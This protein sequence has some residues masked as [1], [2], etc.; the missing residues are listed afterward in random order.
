MKSFILTV[1]LPLVFV[2]LV[3]CKKYEEGPVISL[4]SKKERVAN[5]WKYQA[6]Y[7]N[8]SAEVLS[9]KEINTTLTLT[10]DG[11]LRREERN[12]SINIVGNGSWDFVRDKEQISMTVSYSA[13]GLTYSE[14]N[15][16]SILR[17]K[18]NELWLLEEKNG[19]RFEYHFESL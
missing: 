7:K 9:D 16:Y 18:E 2:V 8:G 10:K 19:D 6:K 11:T 1:T 14:S 4:R 13:F 12:G 15:V 5:T 17:L 3:S